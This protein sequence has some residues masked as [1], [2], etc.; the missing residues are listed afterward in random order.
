MKS[1]IGFAL[2][3]ATFAFAHEA[4]ARGG[5]GRFD[6]STGVVYP[7]DN[8]AL[9]V[10]S[11]SL[12]SSPATFEGLVGPTDQIDAEATLVGSGKGFGWGIGADYLNEDTPVALAGIGVGSPN[13]SLG[14]NGS[15][16]FDSESFGAD[17]GAH[18]GGRSGLA[19]GVVARSLTGGIDA[20]DGGVG[21]SGMGDFRF[22]VDLH[23]G[24]AN[25]TWAI[26]PALAVT[27]VGGKLTLAVGYNQ[28]IEPS[29]DGDVR[30]GISYWFSNRVALEYLYKYGLSDHVVGIKIGLD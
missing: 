22:E 7:S 2:V 15:Y 28:P 21:Y 13:I 8:Q 14:L 30:A 9:Y 27:A 16:N 1:S 17:V 24:V 23:Y 12:I 3:A 6:L 5:K 29:G 26:D 4:Y 19:F 11:S 10:N 18:F 25:S 20:V